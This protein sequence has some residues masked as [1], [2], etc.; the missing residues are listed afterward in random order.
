MGGVKGQG[1]GEVDEM[2]PG[3]IQHRAQ[4]SAW[5]GGGWE[6]QALDRDGGMATSL[7]SFLVRGEV[8]PSRG[9]GLSH[10]MVLMYGGG[11]FGS[12]VPIQEGSQLGSRGR[13]KAAGPS[14]RR[15][16]ESSHK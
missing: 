2:P 14:S 9:V 3:N 7:I 11:V 6:A 10:S 16:G 12:N 1:G 15:G 4:V 13:D 5:S 8:V